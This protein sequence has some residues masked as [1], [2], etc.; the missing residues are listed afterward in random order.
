MAHEPPIIRTR[1]RTK[2][3]ALRMVRA[4]NPPEDPSKGSHP[5]RLPL[6]AD[7]SLTSTN[8]PPGPGER[9]SVPRRNGDDGFRISRMR[10]GNLLLTPAI[11]KMGLPLAA[12]PRQRP[13]PGDCVA[14]LSAL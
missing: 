13:S 7:I 11:W 3:K 10:Y 5:S 2:V 8:V 9:L 14:G 12:Y 1:Y 4:I 6:A